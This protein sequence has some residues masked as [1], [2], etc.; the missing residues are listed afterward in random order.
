MDYEK[1]YNE[2]IP[3]SSLPSDY[4]G[5]LDNIETLH[6][7]NKESLLLLRDYFLIVEQI[8]NFE[9]EDYNFDSKSV[10][11]EEFEDTKI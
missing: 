5:D 1:F 4:Y 6:N 2:C 9:F 3:R 7:R 8:M 10:N 11:G